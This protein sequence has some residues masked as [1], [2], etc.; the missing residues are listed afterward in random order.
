MLCAL[1]AE[2]ENHCEWDHELR[3][4]D[5]FIQATDHIAEVENG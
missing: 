3:F 2:I 4:T 5:A 1:V